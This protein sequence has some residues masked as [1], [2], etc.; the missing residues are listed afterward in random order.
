MLVSTKGRYALRVMIDLAGQPAEVYTPL[1][2]IAERQGISEKYLESIVSLLSKG[3]LVDS[4]RGKSGGYRL[5]RPA[6]EY[7]V[8]EILKA[9]ESTTAPVACLSSEENTCPRKEN[10]P[11][12][13]MWQQVHSI[14][15]EYF[16]GVT[17]AHLAQTE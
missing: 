8:A 7:T 1:T 11:T 4:V 5:N 17:I 9:T 3:G 15:D 6:Q 12:L 13:K 10:C 16:S 14:T 2:D